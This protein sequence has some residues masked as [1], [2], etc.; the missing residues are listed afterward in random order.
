MPPFF[1]VK[2]NKIV[3]EMKM[4]KI[5]ILLIFCFSLSCT[6]INVNK[7][8][9]NGLILK[10]ENERS[11][12]CLREAFEK[13][14]N[15]KELI[16]KI[17]LASGRIPDFYTFKK[18]AKKFGNSKEVADILAVSSMFPGTNFPRKKLVKV[19]SSLPFSGKVAVALLATED[20]TAFNIVLNRNRLQKNRYGKDIA[21]NL[22]RAK[23]LVN[24]DILKEF[25]KTNPGE[26]VYSLFRLKKKGI[27]RAEDLL[28]GDINTKFYGMFVVDYPEKLLDNNKWQ[29]KVAFIKASNS[30]SV[31]RRF[32]SDPNPLVKQ[33]ALEFF[34][35]NNGRV[36]GID[37]NSLTP[38]QLEIILPYIKNKKR[39]AEFFKKGGFYSYVAAPYMTEK[40]YD[41]V[42]KSSVSYFQKLKFLEKIKG[43][44]V[45]IE[46]AMELFREKGNREILSYLT[47]K[48]EQGK[49]K[50]DVFF[51]LVKG[52]QKDYLSF[53]VDAGILKYRP[54]THPLVF[55]LA[56]I[57]EAKKLNSFVIE[58]EE[59]SLKC[60]LFPENA[61]LTCLNFHRLAKSGYYNG[62]FFHRVIPGFVAQAGDPTGTGYGGPN[63]TI[64]CEYNLLT[65]DNEGMVG[66]ALAGK[67]TG[68][69]QFF[70]THIATP[71]LNY[72]YTIFAEVVNGLDTLAKISKFTLI[73]G[74]SFSD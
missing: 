42:M 38:S 15:D 40:D 64:R 26:T 49:L 29:L 34:L 3:S 22:W 8:Y 46:K 35:K 32:L 58:T 25:Y 12:V 71:H 21:F 67:D 10:A 9:L 6:S 4:R 48:L 69:S 33:T 57:E 1:I 17:A 74:V 55:Y 70:I 19:L 72:K 43:E 39:V 11:V 50:K 24:E 51:S 31:S 16:K 44:P 41:I 36:S 7:T 30:L 53:L 65:Y 62:I 23:S 47:E 45:A 56:K 73:K 63:Y 61:P 2:S 20:K 60:K 68:G 66:M 54:E 5:P 28:N 18:V 37:L 27:A 59:G 13:A 52:K 14:G